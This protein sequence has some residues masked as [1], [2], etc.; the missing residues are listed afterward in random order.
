MFLRIALASALVS[1][2]AFGAESA[3]IDGAVSGLRKAAAKAPAGIAID[4]Q[5]RA[6]AALSERHSPC[7]VELALASVERL[8]A[9]GVTLS[10]SQRKTLTSLAPAAAL[11]PAPSAAPAG[12]RA[13]KEGVSPEVAAIGTGIGRL[14]GLP[15]DADRARLVLELTSKIRALPAADRLSAISSLS[16]MVTEG[17]LGP[18]ALGSVAS[19]LAEAL[20]EAGGGGSA[21]QYIDLASLVRYERVPAPPADAALDAAVA[22]LALR[23]R[24]VE[25]AGFAL[26]ALDGKAYSLGELRG[27]VVLLNFWATWCPPCRKEMPD[28][29][30]LYDRFKDKGLVVLAAS[31]EERTTVEQYVRQQGYTFPILLDAESKAQNAFGVEGIPKTFIFDRAGN[32]AAQSV[33][34]RTEAQ[35]LRLL[36]QAGLE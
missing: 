27:R 25:D 22:Y 33:D 8:K 17:D 19:L 5:V 14:R 26:S 32:L 23:E 24:L 20:R 6:A 28:M 12:A 35:F 3:A 31:G 15:T 13:A 1:G 36:K 29:Q 9:G 18:Q 11:P 2:T 10:D 21:G 34:M 30:K 16:H 7:A 4:L